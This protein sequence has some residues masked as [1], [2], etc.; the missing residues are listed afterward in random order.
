[1]VSAMKKTYERPTLAKAG[2]F[3]KVTAGALTSCKNEL[4]FTKPKVL[5]SC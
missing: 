4:I 3:N 1:M 5:G 2:N